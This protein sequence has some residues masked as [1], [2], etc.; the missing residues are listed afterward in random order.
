MRLAKHEHAVRR[1][2]EIFMAEN[3]IADCDLLVIGSGAGGLSAAVT[4]A[5]LGLDVVLI[6]KEAQ[7]GGTTAWSGGWMWIPRNPL[8]QA[9]GIVETPEQPKLYL[10]HELADGYD[11]ARIDMFLDQ[12]PR[13]VEFFQRETRLAFI[14]GN[15]IP[16]FHGKS[17]GAVTGGRSLCA[18]P[19]DGRQTRSTYPRSQASAGRGFPF[20]HGH[21]VGRRSTALPQCPFVADLLPACRAAAGAAF[22][23]PTALRSWHASGQRQRARGAAP[24]SR[25][26]SS[27]SESCL[28]PQRNP[29]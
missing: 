19:F 1:E 28:Q 26:T 20:R 22:P 4:A 29:C 23:R 5:S 21:C 17:P 7:L 16:D 27:A 25:P 8:A 14:D 13:M 18:A 10:R 9:A 3:N 24:E 15:Q 6:E 12:G 11:Q 2:L